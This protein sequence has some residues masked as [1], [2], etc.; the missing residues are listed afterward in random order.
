[1][2]RDKTGSD[3]G[4]QKA[5]RG[6]DSSLPTLVFSDAA[7]SAAKWLALLLMVLDHFNKYV[8]DSS[9]TWMF[10]AGRISMP[11]FTFVLGYNL[12]RPGMLETGGYR[13]VA[14]RLSVFGLVATVP[15]VLVNKLLGGWWPLNMMF[16]LCLGVVVAWLFDK[17]TAWTTISA[18]LLWACG[19][20]LVEY[21]W[22]A[23]G[24]LLC[25]WA[26]QRKPSL[27]LMVG[28]GLNLALLYFV[29][30][31]FWALA[32]VPILILLQRWTVALPLA[33]WIFYG[34]YPV[35]LAAFWWWSSAAN[36]GT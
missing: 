31:N 21:W 7:L 6:E 30:G 15:F 2:S 20:A 36:P 35:H 32:V 25:V 1:M 12:A 18:V 13:R 24:M 10:A 26:Y 16:T 22:P 33:Q 23:L 14:L 29:S 9:Q 3:A 4:A 19:G 11:L 17:G 5:L 34:F 28:F 8:L 27:A